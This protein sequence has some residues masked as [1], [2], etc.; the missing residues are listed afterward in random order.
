MADAVGSP[1]ADTRGCVA[2]RTP[3]HLWVPK[4]Q[5]RENPADA[6][7]CVPA[8]RR[9]IVMMHPTDVWPCPDQPKLGL[10]DQPRHRTFRV[11]RLGRAPVRIILEGRCERFILQNI[12]SNHVQK[13][14]P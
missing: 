5:G 12:Q 8:A 11:Q 2:R 14:F 9:I 3:W 1:R 6:R 10:V 7:A 13:T 4:T